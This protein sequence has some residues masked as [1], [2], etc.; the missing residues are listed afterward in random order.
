MEEKKNI[1]EKLRQAVADIKEAILQGQYE[2]A[3]GINRIQ[4]AVYFGIGK[5]ISQHTRK[6]VWG[7]GALDIISDQLRRELPGLRGYSATNLKNMRL[8]YEAWHM[9]DF[10]SSVVTD[11]KSASAIAEMKDPENQVVINSSVA[12]D[13]LVA[14]DIY[15]TLQVPVTREFPVEDFFKVP[16]THHV[17]IYKLSDLLARYYYIHRTAE[18][19]LSVDDLKKLLKNDAYG[20]DR[21]KNGR[22]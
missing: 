4:L 14:I 5:Y 9:L 1:D 12:T 16:F 13:E 19:H 22:I 3:K 7:T 8:F 10:K 11:E 18:E 15:H 20:G 21:V 6:G 17:E 2:A